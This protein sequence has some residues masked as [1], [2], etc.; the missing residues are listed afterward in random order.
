V[1]ATIAKC[2]RFLSVAKSITAEEGR[3]SRTQIAKLLQKLAGTLRLK[4]PQERITKD[5]QEWEEDVNSGYVVFWV[6]GTPPMGRASCGARV[7]VAM[8]S[9]GATFLRLMTESAKKKSH[10][11]AQRQ[12][13]FIIDSETSRC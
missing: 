9:N 11:I 7:C 3:E 8:K 4:S 13:P 12:I 10:E 6:Q 5:R 2:G 1:V